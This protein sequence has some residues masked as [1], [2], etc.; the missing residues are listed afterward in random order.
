MGNKRPDVAERN[1]LKR[2]LK[3][4][5]KLCECNCGQYSKPGNRFIHS[6]HMRGRKR[7]D[8]VERNRKNSGEKSSWFG[9][10]GPM[11]GRTGEK[12]PNFGR[13]RLDLAE[14][15]KQNSGEKSPNWKGGISTYPYGPGFNDELKKHIREKF[16]HTCVLC[17][18]QA[19]IPHHI[20]YDKNNNQEDNF[21]LL[22]V[23]CNFKVNKNRVQW[24]IYFR[25]Y[26]MLMKL[27]EN[28]HG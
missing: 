2:K 14:R 28:N 20:D 25:M 21:A 8:T 7:L 3:P 5:P 6:H 10:K 16:N 11:F 18:K 17:K 24:E 1:K 12:S 22:C 26:L 9:T 23:S 15:N 27:E 19:N 4:E 13:K